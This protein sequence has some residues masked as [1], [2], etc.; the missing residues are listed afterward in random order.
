MTRHPANHRLPE[1]CVALNAQPRI[2]K[3]SPVY[4][5][6]TLALTGL[7]AVLLSSGA[8]LAA[9]P[10]EVPEPATLSLMA[11]GIGVVAAVRYFRGK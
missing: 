1:A 3:E 9:A 10:I 6:I 11:A 4:R 7:S 5:K 2:F 8:A